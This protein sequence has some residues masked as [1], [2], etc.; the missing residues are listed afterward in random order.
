[1]GA[2]SSSN[3]QDMTM[4][5]IS[6]M[7]TDIMQND[8]LRN[9]ISQIVAVSGVTVH[10]GGVNIRGISQDANQAITLESILKAMDSQSSQQSLSQN[11]SQAA[12]ATV[13]GLNLGNFSSASNSMKGYV[14][15]VTN[16]TTRMSQ[17]CTGENLAQQVVGVFDTV[18]DDGGVNI[19]DVNQKASQE[20]TMKCLMDSKTTKSAI[21]DL[22]QVSSQKATATTVGLDP[23]M[24]VIVLIIVV[25]VGLTAIFAGFP[26]KKLFMILIIVA[27]I[28]GFI[29]NIFF[30]NPKGSFRTSKKD[31]IVA[32]NSH[33]GSDASNLVTLS[34]STIYPTSDAVKDDQGEENYRKWLQTQTDKSDNPGNA[35]KY[36]KQQGYKAYEWIG[37]TVNNS[38]AFVP[39]PSGPTVNFY[40]DISKDWTE[41]SKQRDGNDPMKLI[42]LESDVN[43]KF[44]ILGRP[45]FHTGKSNNPDK[46]D[47]CIDGTNANAKLFI[48]ETDGTWPEKETHTFENTSELIVGELGNDLS[49]PPSNDGKSFFLS[50]NNMATIKLF[51]KSG[52]EWNVVDTAKGSGMIDVSPENYNTTGIEMVISDTLFDSD[53]S[54]KLVGNITIGILIAVLVYL[55]F[56]GSKN[57]EDHNGEGYRSF[58]K[59]YENHLLLILVIIAVISR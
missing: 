44:N 40:S 45:T 36:C 27:I 7:T 32:M 12:T 24:M 18:V 58:L 35:G 6:N 57:K 37:Y 3:K 42:K 1:M 20:A 11:L 47:M 9:Q 17:T 30:V 23:F 21:Q 55:L 49:P 15:A 25:G 33:V 34:N 50:T 56:T 51:E 31:L 29:Y 19:T 22:K 52:N 8:T 13:K 14:K 54:T 16:Q 38:G 10:T 48:C 41:L 5:A 39:L 59:K 53:V 43:K 46:G 26:F 28:A 2:A 4:E